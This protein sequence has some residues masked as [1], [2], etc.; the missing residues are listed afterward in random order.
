MFLERF[1]LVSIF[2]MK[3]LN[4]LRVKY[5]IR[6][7]MPFIKAHALSAGITR[8]ITPHMLRHSFAT[9]LLENGADLRSLQVM[10]GHADISTTQ[11]YTHVAKERLK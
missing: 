1:L 3:W 11:I 9:H 2:L 5:E 6:C 8:N 7:W 4:G 10:L